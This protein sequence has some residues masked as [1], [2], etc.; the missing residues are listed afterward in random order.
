[1]LDSIYHMTIFDMKMLKIYHYV[2]NIAMNIITY[3]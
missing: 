3:N 1:M 2:H